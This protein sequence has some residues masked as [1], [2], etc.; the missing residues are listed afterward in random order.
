MMIITQV[1]QSSQS[2]KYTKTFHRIHVWM[3]KCVSLS[4]SRLGVALVWS[5]YIIKGFSKRNFWNHS[6]AIINVKGLLVVETQGS[7]EHIT[8]ARASKAREQNLQKLS[9][10]LANESQVAAVKRVASRSLK[11][12]LGTSRLRTGRNIQTSFVIGDVYRLA[13]VLTS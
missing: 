4:L 8:S 12:S 7:W 11:M 10:L 5:A 3:Y 1:G 13:E 9:M 2:R 6:V